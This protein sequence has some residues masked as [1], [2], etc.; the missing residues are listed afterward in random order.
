MEAFLYP[1]CSQALKISTTE[2]HPTRDGVDVVT[3][4]CPIHG[5]IWTSV[6]VDQVEAVD[7]EIAALLPLSR[8]GLFGRRDRTSGEASARAAHCCEQSMA[9]TMWAS[10][11]AKKVIAML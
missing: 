5:D 8:H 7:T 3:Y 9:L 10:S 4:R 1:T 11:D 6:V 2:L